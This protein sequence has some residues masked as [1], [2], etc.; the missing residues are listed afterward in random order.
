MK[1]ASKTVRI[2]G[3]GHAGHQGRAFNAELGSEIRTNQAPIAKHCL[4]ELTVVSEDIATIAEALALADRMITRHRSKQWARHLDLEIPVF[5]RAT[6]E[7][8]EVYQALLDA[9]C[10]LTGDDWSISFTERAGQPA[11][12]RY[13]QLVCDDPT[14]VV[15][16]SNGLDSF[17]QSELLKADHGERAVWEVRAGKLQRGSDAPR[18]SLVEVPRRFYAG[19]PRELSYRTRPIVYFSIAAIAAAT[20]KSRYIAIGENGQGSL[21]PAFA[22]FSSE[23]PFRSTHPG[24]IA[25]LETFLTLALEADFSFTQPQLWRTKGEVVRELR[26]RGLLGE[27]L[28]RDSCSARPNQRRGF[29]GCGYCGGC[30]LKQ[31][32]IFAAGVNEAPLVALDYALRTPEMRGEP[33]TLNEREIFARSAKSM[34]L[35]ADLSSRPDR[36]VQIARVAREIPSHHGDRAA[37]LLGLAERHRDEWRGFVHSLPAQSWLK[38]QFASA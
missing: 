5:H 3:T 37:K 18:A 27:G 32:A 24:F 35:F 11:K 29:A 20:S 33:I 16:Y 38:E 28:S 8:S 7:R 1:P 6:F 19:H 4:R 21:G 22:R 13:L 15:P 25:R 12:E 30:L 14:Y 34:D 10:F 23:W 36:D 31:T 17:A 2:S 26:E 9:A